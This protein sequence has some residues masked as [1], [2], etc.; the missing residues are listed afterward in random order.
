M[1][2]ANA[3][4]KLVQLVSQLEASNIPW[5]RHQAG[6]CQTLSCWENEAADEGAGMFP[7]GE[8]F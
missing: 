1:A 8:A 6:N 5:R 3:L 4:L 7:E 2:A